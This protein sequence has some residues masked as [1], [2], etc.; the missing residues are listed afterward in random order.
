MTEPKA[1]QGGVPL[2]IWN[3]SKET[4]DLH[5]TILRIERSNARQTKAMIWMTA[6]AAVAA[7]VA[8]IPVVQ[9]WLK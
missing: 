2:D 3:G 5:E 9:G 7:V 1:K 6:I 4:K 8:A